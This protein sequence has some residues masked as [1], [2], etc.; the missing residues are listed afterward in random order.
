MT[1]EEYLQNI[2]GIDGTF[3]RVTFTYQDTPYSCADKD[4]FYEVQNL[5]NHKSSLFVCFTPM[6]RVRHVLSTHVASSN[7]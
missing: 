7:K 5:D 6:E 1:L 2:E 3:D 4:R